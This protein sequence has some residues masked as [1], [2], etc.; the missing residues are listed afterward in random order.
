MA[1]KEATVGGTMALLLC[2]PGGRRLG[3]WASPAE[4]L[5]SARLLCVLLFETVR[6][7]TPETGVERDAEV[8][9]EEDTDP[10]TV[11]MTEG[12]DVEKDY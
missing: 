3:A 10:P 1:S 2:T 6:S 9:K 11:E 8:V 4:P 7:A 5:R 12:G